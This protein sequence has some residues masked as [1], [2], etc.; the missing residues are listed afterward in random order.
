MN[1]RAI[2]D[3]FRSRAAERENNGD[4]EATGLQIADQLP[5]NTI[6]ISDDEPNDQYDAI[7]GVWNIG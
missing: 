7:T 6:Y 3:V 4:T 5:A 1:G 2:R